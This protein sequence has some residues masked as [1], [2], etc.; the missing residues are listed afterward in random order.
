MPCDYVF[1]RGPRKNTQ[2]GRQTVSANGNK[3][4]QHTQE[5]LDARK[6]YQARSRA[7]RMG[8]DDMIV[9]DDIR[10]QRRQREQQSR[11]VV[12]TIT[13]IR[14]ID[15]DPL[16]HL[17]PMNDDDPLVPIPFPTYDPDPSYVP[18]PITGRGEC[19]CDIPN[20]PPSTVEY[21]KECPIC[22]Y[23]VIDDKYVLNNCRHVY[24]RECISN[25]FILEPRGKCQLCPMCR[26]HLTLN[27]QIMIH[28]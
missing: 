22:L 21:N 12:T 6:L 9:M 17:M 13:Y 27:D 19:Q 26:S 20:N 18:Q 28:A 15:Y 11:V 24:H 10:R 5:A 25:A 3:C 1:S 8:L 16:R 7:R 4:N 2:C 23:D 14:R